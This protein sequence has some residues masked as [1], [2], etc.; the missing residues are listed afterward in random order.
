M[1]KAK[2]S[3]G[4]IFRVALSVNMKELVENLR[5]QLNE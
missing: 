1:E 4:A 3:A 5:A 2:I